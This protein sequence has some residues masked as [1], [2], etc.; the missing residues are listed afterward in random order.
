MV[1]TY[2]K[3]EKLAREKHIPSIVHVIDMTQ[4]TGHSTSGSHER[5]K[6]K[7]RLQWE[8]DYDCLVQFKKW[9]LDNKIASEEELEKINKDVKEFVKQ[10]KREAWQEYQNPLKAELN[11][12]FSILETIASKCEI[13]RT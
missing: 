3:A 6:S 9:I 11:E 1:E 2:E 10:S 13:Q 7:E 8:Q 4:P 5:Y 12:L